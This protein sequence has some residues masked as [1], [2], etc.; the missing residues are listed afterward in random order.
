M[1]ERYKKLYHLEHRL[2]ASHAPVLIES[3][4]LL[5][6]QQSSVMLC[7][8]CFR[9]VQDQPIKSLRAV[10]QLLDARGKPLGNPVDHRYTDLELKRE[11]TCGR[12][13]AIVL[14]ACQAASFRV[15]VAQVSLADGQLWSDEEARWLPLPDQLSLEDEQADPD[16]VKRCRRRFGSDSAFLPVGGEELWF[17]VCGAVNAREES[18][19]HRCRRRRSSLLGERVAA[20]SAEDREEASLRSW[21]EP[22]ERKP[23][24]KGG[25]IVVSALVL[26]GL[27][28]LLLLPR[29]RSGLEG[30]ELRAQAALPSEEPAQERDPRQD[31]YERAL[32]LQEKADYAPLEDAPGLYEQAILAFED[33]G[34]YEDSAQ[35]AEQCRRELEEQRLTL[36]RWGGW[37][38]ARGRPRRP[39]SARPTPSM[40]TCRAMT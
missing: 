38:T 40:N 19:C 27:L 20:P 6:E 39:C 32:A 34:D 4:A 33:L 25:L 36:L 28:A 1:S 21:Q 37:R 13:S 22:A 30:R 31:A 24:R 8:L 18:R 2:Y 35:R 5:L 29:I 12:D 10:V 26:L 17:C 3:G 14:P 7:Q 9:N 16:E 15:Q 23:R 11:E